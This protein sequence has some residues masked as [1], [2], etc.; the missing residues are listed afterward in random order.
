MTNEQYYDLIRPYEDAGRILNTRLEVLSHSLYRDKEIYGPIHNIQS[1]IKDKK[2]VEDKLQ[3]LKLGDSMDNAR[4]FLQDIA[5]SRVICYFV[6]DIYNLSSLLKRQQDLVVIKERDYI[7]EPK[8]NGYRSY[9]LV[10]GVPV[11]CMDAMEYF[12]VE[13]QLR[14]MAMDF[15]ASMEHRVCYKKEIQDK[16]QLAAE[17]RRYG[18]VLEGIE[19]EFEA[20]N[21]RKR[22][23]PFGIKNVPGP[24]SGK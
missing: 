16:D 17:F 3:R 12:P 4:D 7:R 18:R 5:G 23:S 6:D 9:H 10:L 20:Y 8:P 19:Q 22:S 15:W 1:R 14:T 11:Y 2:S 24:D 21:T 13:V